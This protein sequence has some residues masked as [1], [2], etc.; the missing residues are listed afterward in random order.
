[1]RCPNCRAENAATRRFC[2]Q[3]GAAFPAPCPACGF[4]NE[5]TAKFCGGCGRPV[6][7][8]AIKVP[9]AEPGL[10]RDDGAERRQLT[11][12]FCDLVG[13]TAL[14]SRLDPEDLRDV[15][16]VYHKSV[17]ETL[18]E[19]DGFVA[20]YMGDGVLV[21]FGYPRAQEDS[22]ERAV[23]AGLALVD[24]IGR[25]DLAHAKLEL[26]VGIAT[27]LVVVGDLVGVGESAER[28]VIGVTPNLAARL[29][30]LAKP[31]AVL[32]AESTR[33]LLGALF[34]Y[35]SLGL[36]DVK[37]LAQA[38]PLWQVLG[39]GTI[40]SRFEALRAASL[41]PLVGREDE[42]ELLM[43][44]W[45]RAK[46]AE[47]Q[48]VLLSGE[49]GIGKS[50]ITEALYERMRDEAHTRLRCFCSPH[51]RDSP[52]HPFISRLE[53]AAGFARE[54]P[55]EVKLDKLETLLSQSEENPTEAAAL[56]ADLLAVPNRGRY[57]PLPADPQRRRELTFM[58]FVR[59][60][61]GL[62]EKKPVLMIFEDAHWIDSTSL[63]LLELIVESVPRLPVLFLATFR[64]ELELPWTGQP[65]VTSLTLSRLGHRE[66]ER[67]AERVAGG[68]SLPIEI[69]DQIVERADGIP[70]FIE[71][72]TKTLLEG[73]LLREQDGHFVLSGPLPPLAIPS[74]LHASLLA[75]LDRLAPVK[76]VAQI[77]AGL[78]REF[79]YEVLAAVARRPSEQL[80]DALDR[81]VNAG[82]VFRRGAPPRASFIF[83]HALVQ[84]AAYSTLLRSQRQELHARIGRVLEEQFPEISAAQPEIM[85][86]HYTQ[87]GITSTA[88]EYWRTAGERAYRRSA[89]VEATKHLTQGLE[90]IPLLRAGAERDRKE[91]GLSLALGRV[92]WA[93]K[94][95]G[96]ET[97]RV[98]CR[99]RD[100]LDETATVGERMAV[101]NGLW[102]VEVHR[103]KLAATRELA[104]EALRLAA[105]H[106]D[107][108]IGGSANSRMGMTLCLMGMFAD[109]RQHLQRAL[110]CYAIGQENITSAGSIRSGNALLLLGMT[111]WALGYPEQAVAAPAKALADA[112]GSGHAVAIGIAL[113]WNA[114]LEAA[115]GASPPSGKSHA[116]EAAAHCAERLRMYE[117][118]ARFN[119]GILASRR[120]NP[121]GGI[122][123]MKAA[124][125]TAKEFDAE[126]LRPLHLAHLAAAHA[127]L[128]QPRIGVGLLDE[129]LKT[130]TD[131]EERMF[132]AE[133]L[134]LR[135]ELLLGLGAAREAETAFAHALAVAR[136]QEARMWE[137][138]AAES[139]ARLW[140][141]RGRRAEARELLAPVYD[142]FSEG[143]DT[144]DLKEAKGLLD[145]LT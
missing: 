60:L 143:S 113:F 89:L 109:A 59:Q 26:R 16:G 132:E 140:A 115:F 85:A 65:H 41:T 92:T 36:V 72:L 28:T 88:I 93:T 145:E 119:Q 81:L 99:A 30:A 136:G 33:R 66:T 25:L 96:A 13:S 23:R 50:R 116:D 20:K 45:A 104:Q 130:A 24:S 38:V 69:L 55:P 46:Q 53:R 122:E 106:R 90:L 12:M 31:N 114:F 54:D 82:L 10:S 19:F 32:I 131:T 111:L 121:A 18:G 83:K 127:T 97:F 52:L 120:G 87:A 86:Y 110:D 144:A 84:D 105:L 95:H 133:L 61:Q 56:F 101:L 102:N 64:P 68:K 63:E 57:P 141:E 70:L 29:Q 4:E 123:I 51:H 47:G 117:P 91:L 2:A 3:C 139:L 100:L 5:P 138:R 79:S 103:A 17:A 107:P 135:G 39:P 35:R 27:G 8:L 21:Y 112:R 129:A 6:D 48:I 67:L 37:G 58:A 98:Y 80:R 76:E 22:A 128:G 74:S 14:A 124:M 49:A 77:G 118:W 42:I 78:G 1:M 75:R 44:R 34:E 43:R 137:L 142:W 134:R 108:Q 126:L 9:V 40:R 94:G 125:A 62:A 73:S 7:G 71:E 11:V 15:I